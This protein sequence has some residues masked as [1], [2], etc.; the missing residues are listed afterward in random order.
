MS[1]FSLCVIIHGDQIDEINPGAVEN[2]LE[3]MM[4]P[5][6]EDTEISRNATFHDKTDE[7]RAEYES[8]PDHQKQYPTFEDFCLKYHGYEK[9]AHKRWGYY[10]NDL[11]TWD[12]YVIGG[13]F[14]GQFL[15]TSDNEDVLRMTEADEAKRPAPVGY[16]FVNAVR[17]KDVAWEKAFELSVTRKKAEYARLAKAFE[18]GDISDLDSLATIRENGIQIW[19]NTL[20]RK[21]KTEEEYLARTGGSPADFMPI[22]VY[23]VLTRDGEWTAHGTMGW[24]GIS[25]DEKP[26]RD[27][28]DEIAELVKEIQPDDILVAVDCHI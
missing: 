10:Y 11:A 28:Y 12:W 4:A 14:P 16:R 25:T 24:W 7:A 6:C 20:Y 19:G 5:Y 3:A 1:H 9:C 21:G 26:E 18:T 13:R 27:W 15:T 23:A 17:M 2:A 22:D 8:S